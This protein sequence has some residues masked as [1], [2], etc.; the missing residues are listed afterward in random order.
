M[1]KRI[2]R[3]WLTVIV[4]RNKSGD[5]QEDNENSNAGFSLLDS[6]GGKE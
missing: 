2:L 1:Q 5:R 6:I 3:N 4:I